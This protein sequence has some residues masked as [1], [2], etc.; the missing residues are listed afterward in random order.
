MHTMIPEQLRVLIF[1]ETG[2]RRPSQ[3]SERVDHAIRARMKS[4]RFSSVD[5]YSKL[6]LAGDS[7]SHAEVQQLRIALTNGETHFFRDKGQFALL[8]RTLLPELIRAKTISKTLRIWSAACATGEEAHSLAIVLQSLIEHRPDLNVEILGTDI[9]EESLHGARTAVYSS[10]SFR[11]VS[12]E[13]QAAHFRQDADHWKLKS[14]ACDI[15]FKRVD[16]IHDDFPSILSGTCDFDLILCRNVF[17]YFEP[18]MIQKVV[19]KMTR[20]L[21][22]GGYL[23]TAHGELHGQKLDGLKVLTF[24][25]SCVYQRTTGTAAVHV[26]TPI[27]KPAVE[28]APVTP[29]KTTLE[30]E[31]LA[32]HAANEGDYQAAEKWCQS[33]LAADPF[34]TDIYYLLAKIS[35]EQKQMERA[36]EMLKK[37]LYIDPAFVSA[38]I[39][40]AAIYNSENDRGRA[41]KLRLT[42][43]DYLRSRKPE[44][45]IEIYSTTAGE[46]TTAIEGLLANNN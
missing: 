41:R 37:A 3:G 15:Q 33:A 1:S 35:E 28:A 9:N 12:T 45:R 13:R 25:E 42:A 26:P 4:W 31:A 22:P 43:L 2:L 21:R 29:V 44:E 6:L 23:L 20:A 11:G 17:I 30:F 8:E 24:P 16:L 38:Y 19:E 18:R 5:Q 39:E 32:R 27:R 14:K 34:A 7:N 46:L 40:L 36:K 10:W